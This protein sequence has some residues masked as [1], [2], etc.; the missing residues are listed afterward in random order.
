[1][2]SWRL[3]PDQKCDDFR[4]LSEL[5]ARAIEPLL[6]PAIAPEKRGLY[7]ATA[8]AGIAD[9]LQ[10]WA[11]ALAETPRFASPANFPF[12]LANAPAGQLARELCL[13]GPCYTLVGAAEAVDAA[14]DHA[15]VDLDQGWVEEAVVVACNLGPAPR[16]AALVVGDV[17]ELGQSDVRAWVGAWCLPP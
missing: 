5:I 4:A 9:T 11:A 3:S 15:L 12:C 6:S 7:L 1:M 2:K 8:D 13:R 10:F 16:A 14:I 17:G